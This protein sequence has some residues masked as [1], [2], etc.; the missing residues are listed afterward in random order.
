M[1]RQAKAWI[2]GPLAK[3]VLQSPCSWLASIKRQMPGLHSATNDSA[4]AAPGLHRH[5]GVNGNLGA[6]GRPSVHAA[7]AS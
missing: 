2:C 3:K 4:G 5:R 1:P 6:A 7:A